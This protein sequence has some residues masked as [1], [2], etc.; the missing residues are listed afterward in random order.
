MGK[1]DEITVPMPHFGAVLDWDSFSSIAERITDAKVSFVI[2][3]TLRFEGKSGEQRT[4][5]FRDPS[6]NAIEFKSF[7][8]ELQIFAS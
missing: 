7:R 1:V 5:F 3:P 6:G 4:M 8:D 2:A